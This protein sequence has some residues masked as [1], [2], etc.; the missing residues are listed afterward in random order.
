MSSY[1]KGSYNQ[2]S[3]YVDPS[4]VSNK[5]LKSMM[6]WFYNAQY[7]GASAIWMQGAIDKRF[8]IGDSSLYSSAWGQNYQQYQK[9]FFNLIRRHGNMI[10]GFQRKNRK[11]T[12]TIPNQEDTDEL[13][14][15]YNKALRWCEDRDNFQ[16]YF[17]QSFEGGI[18][19]GINWL[20]MYP[21]Y[22]Y[23]PVSGDLFTDSV[24]F[25]NVL[26]DQNFHKMDLTDCNGIWRRRWVSRQTL[27]SLLPGYEEELKNIRPSGAK[28]GRFPLQAELQNLQLSNLFTYDEFYYRSS[29]KAKII[30][31]PYTGEATEWEEREDDEEDLIKQILYQQPWLKVVE[32]DIPT[33]K[34]VL[35][36]GDKIVYHGANFL[37]VDEYPCVPH[38]C[39]HE[40]DVLSYSGRIMGYIRNVR[41]AQ[42]LYNMRKV[43]ELQILQSQINAGWIY[44]IDAVTDP[45][46]FRQASGGDAF[47]IPLKAGRLP[48]EIQRIEPTSIPQSL[49]ELSRNLAEDITNITG[50]NEEL[51]GMAQDD[52]AGILAM[53]RQSAGLVTLQTIF[54]KSD[55]TQRLYGKLR[56][57]AIRKNFSK[58]KVRA[59]LGKDPDPRFFT[60]ISQKYGVSVEE[61]NYSTTQRQTELQQYLTFKEMGIPIPD[62]TIIRAAFITNKKQLIQDMEEQ[63]QGQMQQ[64]QQQAQEQSQS[65]QAKTMVDQAKAQELMA[66]A[67]EKLSAVESNMASTEHKQTEADLNILKIA[68]EL[69]GIQLTQL[70]QA[71]DLV[72]AMKQQQSGL[73]PQENVLQTTSTGEML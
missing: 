34:M 44:P 16:E 48:S 60:D 23:D 33:V 66:S 19:V 35:Q 22:T 15:N 43:I 73:Q 67:S 25:N 61:G 38:L 64:Q 51:L 27:N 58:G 20:W 55:M 7:T 68:M 6:D 37:N 62:K 39:Y 28:D 12:I 13:C 57:K 69:E 4:D 50:V 2:S 31:D 32:K 5:N 17:S 59:I 65:I 42:F 30:I 70:K 29:R 40:P 46:A 72:Y 26:W 10:S 14:D 47:L 8:K 9:F 56:L 36:V 53:L 52:K 3:G 49:I 41:D 18:D 71:I 1:Q 21:D 45:K 24:S 54:D 11:S 63:A